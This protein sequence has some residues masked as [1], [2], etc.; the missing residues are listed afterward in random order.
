MFCQSLKL[1]RFTQDIMFLSTLGFFI[2]SN[3]HEKCVKEL[4]NLEILIEL[5]RV[6]DYLIKLQ[7]L[8]P[9]TFM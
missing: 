5:F 4:Q 3:I 9:S 1:Q 6:L 8:D 7:L 2:H